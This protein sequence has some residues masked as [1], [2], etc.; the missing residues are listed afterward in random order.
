MAVCL[1]RL[2]KASSVHWNKFLKHISCI[3]K[4]WCFMQELTQSHDRTRM[5]RSPKTDN[6]SCWWFQP[7]W[8]IFIKLNHFPQYIGVR[9]KATHATNQPTNQR[10]A[11]GDPR[12]SSWTNARVGLRMVTRWAFWCLPRKQD[13]HY[14]SK[15]RA[16]RV[17]NVE[18]SQSKQ[19]CKVIILGGFYAVIFSCEVEKNKHVNGYWL[20]SGW[21]AALCTYNI[22]I[23]IKNI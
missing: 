8:K 3:V 21:I 18:A 7:T 15:W 6:N 5:K 9:N 19:V 11:C 4:W 23:D 20:S 14:R 2:S 13:F 10:M 22:Y 1:P 12:L 17:I 16:F